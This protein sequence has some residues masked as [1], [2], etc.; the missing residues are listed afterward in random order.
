[1]FAAIVRVPAGGRIEARADNAKRTCAPRPG[2][3]DAC[4]D[5]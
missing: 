5:R 4:S 2:A 3:G 1:M